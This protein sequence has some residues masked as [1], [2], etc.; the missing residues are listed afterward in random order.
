MRKTRKLSKRIAMRRAGA[1]AMA[2]VLTATSFNFPTNVYA[3]EYTSSWKKDVM[4][5]LDDVLDAMGNQSDYS[6]ALDNLNESLNNLESAATVEGL[7]VTEVGSDYIK[8]EWEPFASDELTGYDV[9]FADKDTETQV[10]Q[11]LTSDG[12]KTEDESV[13]TVGS[14]TTSFI[15]KKSTHKNYYF[16]V[17][18]VVA[19]NVGSKTESVK[20]PTANEFNA[21]LE[22][23]DRGLVMVETN[24]G[25]FLSWRLLG[26]EVTG[27]NSTGLTGTD[28]NVY[29]DGEYVATVT[30]STN[31]VVAGGTKD[32][33]YTVVPVVNG[34]EDKTSVS[35][36][37][38]LMNTTEGAG[39]LDIALQ[40]PHD[41][42][43]E[44]TYGV[45][46]AEITLLNSTRTDAYTTTNITYSANDV[47][48][49]DVDGDGEY[50][51]FV[52]WDPSLSKDV[53]QQGYT[54]KQYI[55]CYELDGTLLYR[56]DLG[57]NIRAGAHY[58]QFSVF[59][60]NEDGKAELSIKTA[61]GT[62][63]LTFNNNN[64]DDIATE[65]Y[66]TTP[67][68]ESNDA[69]Y[70]YSAADY[71]EH[72]VNMF[73]DWGVWANDSDSMRE[74]KEKWDKNLI[75]L[76]APEDGT[77]TR[78]INDN[79]TYTSEIV[80]REEAGF[81]EDDVLVNV[82]VRD[83]NGDVVYKGTGVANAYMETVRFDDAKTELTASMYHEGGYSREE[84]EALADYF[85]N[86]YQ[87]RMKKHNLNYYEGYIISG[88][89][90]LS[91]FEGATGR[92][93]D[94]IMYEF[95]REDDGMLWGDYAMNYME[96]G[97]RCDR[98]LTTVAYLDGENPY[99][100]V[101]RGYY[102]RATIATYRITKE[103]KLE[104]YWT[105]DSGWTVMTN[106]FN[107]GPHGM[108]GNN[109]N[110]GTNGISFSLFSGQ[111]D[112]YVV[113][114]DVD[115]DGRQEIVYGGAIVDDNGDLYSSG[116][117]L[118]PDGTWAKYG[119]GDSIHVTD[120]D[121]DRPGLEIFSCF[122]GGPGAP[123]GTA[124]RDAE[125]NTTIPG[126]FSV[127]TGLD[128]G[129]C[130]IGDI[131]PG[132]RGL[133]TWG[134]NT[135]D[136]KGNL[137]SASTIGTNQNIRWSADMTTQIYTGNIEKCEGNTKSVVL[138]ATGTAS[139]NGTKGN[140]G[141]IAD[142]FGDWREE[143]I[144]RTSDN[145]AL[146]IYTNTEVTSHK[147]YTLMHDTQYR[148]NVA[149]QNTAYNQPSY[150]GFYFA[151]DTDWEYVPLP[152]A[153][154]EQ[155]PGIVEVQPTGVTFAIS[156]LLVKTGDTKNVNATVVPAKATDKTLTYISS[157]NNIA[158]VDGNGDVT[159]VSAGTAIITA[160]T[161]NG[162]SM[163]CKVIVKDKYTDNGTDRFAIGDEKTYTFGSNG[164]VSAFTI[165][166]EETGYGFKTPNEVVLKDGED[167][168]SGN[169]V[170]KDNNGT[171]TYEYP[172]FVLDVPAG[173]YE[174]TLTQGSDDEDSVTGAYVEGN[175]YSVRWSSENFATSYDEPSENSYIITK[176]G[177]RKVTTVKTAVCDGQLTIDLAT[178]VK[179][180]GSSLTAYINN[181][182]VKRI[183]QDT[184]ESAN[185][186]LRFI[187][188]STVASY[189]PEDGGNWTPIP[190]RTGWGTDFAM[191]R[192]MD[193]SVTLV[194]KAV[195]GS[196]IKSYIA[197]GYYNDFF[198][199]SKPGDTVIIE[200]GINDSAAGRRYS[201]GTSYEEYLRYYIES[202][203][204]FG[205]DVILSSGTSS[206]TTYTAVQEKLA[207]EYELPY[208]DLL[209]EF[210]NYK[211][212]INQTAQG[213]LTVDGTHLSRVGGVLAAQIVANSIADIEGYSLSGHVL[214]KIVNDKA[215]QAVVTG[216]YKK[217]QTE[218][219]V[220]IAWNIDEDTLYN[221]DELI[222]RFNIY[223]KAKGEDDSK[224]E[225]V[226]Q[227]RAYVQASMTAPKLMATIES[228]EKGDYEYAVSVVG[229]KG[230][231]EK[232][233]SVCI[234]EFEKTD[235]YELNELI[236]KYDSKQMYDASHYTVE[237]Y[238][239]LIN[240]INKAKDSISREDVS[241][242][243]IKK[244]LEEV[245]SL[246]SA[247]KLNETELI[248]TDFE[249]EKTGSLWGTT[250]NQLL[251]VIMEEDGN[252]MANAYVEA[253]GTRNIKKTITGVDSKLLTVEFEWLP[254]NPDT[255]NCTEIQFSDASGVYFSLKTSNN[256]HIGYVV[257]AYPSDDTS[258]LTGDGFHEGNKYATDCNIPN[259]IWYNVRVVFDYEEHTADLYFVPR[260]NEEVAPVIV[261]DIAISEAASQVTLMNFLC[262]RGKQDNGVTND[263]SVLWNTYLDNFLISYSDTKEIVDASEYNEIVK[264]LD[265]A[266]EGIN[267]S[268][269]TDEIRLAYIIEDAI[270]KDTGYYTESDYEYAIKTIKQAINT[271]PTITKVTSINATDCTVLAGVKTTLNVTF[272]PENSNEVISAGSSSDALKVT[273]NGNKITVYSEEEITAT[274]TVKTAS[275]LTKDVK[276]NV[277]GKYYSFGTDAQ[278]N[279][280]SLYDSE[281]GYGFVNYEYPSEALG[282]VDG[283]YHKRVLR[284][285]LGTSYIDTEASTS[286]YLAVNSV[287]WREQ[288]GSR[289]EDYIR[290]E[291]TQAFVIDK[292]SGNYKVA[293]TFTNP[294]KT[295][296]TVSVIAQDIT[297]YSSGDHAGSELG[298][299]KLNAGET[300]TAEFE[301][302]LMDSQIVLRFE[303]DVT[304]DSYE[305]AYPQTVYVKGVTVA[306][307]E[308]EEKELNTIYVLGDSTV[309]TYTQTGYRTGWGQ[310]LYNILKGA[311]DNSIIEET[312]TG[313]ADYVTD[314]FEVKNYARDARSA[315]SFKE[316][317]RLNE[318]LL[319]VSEGDYVLAQ[320]THNDSNTA[321]PNRYLSE[322]EFRQY[323]LDY[324]E[325]VTKRGATFVMVTPIALNVCTDGNWDH[326][327]ESYRKVMLEL[328]KTDN[329]PVID[330][331][332]SS[333]ALL[334]ELGSDTVAALS[335]YMTDTV[336]LQKN[337]ADMYARLIANQINTY[338]QSNKLDS[339][340]NALKDSTDTVTLMAKE[341]ELNVN[342]TITLGVTYTGTQPDY[343]F[344]SSDEAVATVDEKGNVTA[345]GKGSAVI[346]AVV[347][348]GDTTSIDATVYTDYIIINVASEKEDEI[349]P[350][351]N[352]KV[353]SMES[354][355]SDIMTTKVAD[356]QAMINTYSNDSVKDEYI[357]DEVVALDVEDTNSENVSVDLNAEVEDKM[358]KAM[359]KFDFG[360]K[361]GAATGYTN[362]TNQAYTK[363]IGYGFTS[364]TS[365]INY[366]S[367]SVGATLKDGADEEEQALTAACQDA[368]R[369]SEFEFAIDL[370]A[371]TY[372]LTMYKNADW[373]L[374]MYQNATYTVNGVP[375]RGITTVTSTPSEIAD[376][377]KVTLKEDGQ[378]IVKG[379]N[380]NKLAIMN[381]IV[382]SEYVD[383][384]KDYDADAFATLEED[385]TKL[386]I[387]ASL[388]ADDSTP[389]DYDAGLVNRM[390]T[391]KDDLRT[392]KNMKFIDLKST[393]EAKELAREALANKNLYT[394]KSIENLNKALEVLALVEDNANGT[395][396]IVKSAINTINYWLAGI[397]TDNV[398]ETYN[399]YVDFDYVSTSVEYL[400][401]GYTSVLNTD[402]YDAEKGYGLS[403]A[404][405]GRNRGTGDSLNDDFV[406]NNTF[407]A[408][409][410]AGTYI[411]R[412]ICGDLLSGANNTSKFTITDAT[413]GNILLS[414]VSVA[415]AGGSVNSVDMTLTLNADTQVNITFT[416]RLNALLIDEKKAI[417][418]QDVDITELKELVEEIT[419]KELQEDDYTVSSFNALTEALKDA[420]EL[421]AKETVYAQEY[422]KVLSALKSA[423]EGLVPKNLDREI[424][425]DF[426]TETSPVSTASKFSGDGGIDILGSEVI[427]GL[428]SML[429]SSNVTDNGQHFG[430]DREVL[431]NETSAGGAHFRDYV[432]TA[433]GEEY[434]FS[435]DLP[436]GTYYIY[437][438]TGDKLADN[439]TK[440]YLGDN[441]EVVNSNNAAV[442]EKDGKTVYTQ[443]SN[444]GGQ[445]AAPGAIYTVK[446][447][448]SEVAC[449]YTG[450]K[451]GRFSVTL[452]NDE[453][454]ADAITARLN[455]IEIT[456]FDKNEPL[457][458]DEKVPEH[459]HN[460][461]LTEEKEATCTEDGYKTYTCECGDSY[462][463]T[464]S[465]TGHNYELTEEK[466]ATC[467]EDG[468]R[469]YTCA[470][471]KDTYK[472]VI[473]ATGH[474]EGEWVV[475]KEAGKTEDGVRS[476]I[477]TKCN[478]VLDTEV[479]PNLFSQVTVADT[480]DVIIRSR[481][482]PQITLPAGLTMSDIKVSYTS[483]RPYV[484]LPSNSN[485]D[486]V[487]VL[488]G[489]ATITTTI[490]CED[491]TRTFTTFVTIDFP[492][493]EIVNGDLTLARGEQVKLQVKGVGLTG[494]FRY[495]STNPFVVKVTSDGEI[496]ALRKGTSYVY[497]YNN[498]ALDKIKV[499]VR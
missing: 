189:P 52:K 190:E 72:L 323:L 348:N 47:S 93:L 26:S 465:A 236:E 406:M 346:T 276:V 128:T 163:T 263:L 445:F 499:V 16:K 281:K 492:E 458:P 31:Y 108:N 225:K 327:F 435:M 149:G 57:I 214:K 50:E 315:K 55:D 231:G 356:S 490:T 45:S 167:Y 331:M 140:A 46:T 22:N 349:N 227:Q 338:N 216:V 9:Y 114:A 475:T 414:D 64:Q 358:P 383:E 62:K 126:K 161:V 249:D 142:I 70:V 416:G 378:V 232:S 330:L 294:S 178:A 466:E 206:G 222:T 48:V 103:G 59:D 106:P 14:D 27:Y 157:D 25:V 434:T 73:M 123:F 347:S 212:T 317:G 66:I 135:T 6:N 112:H 491:V 21:Y 36:D 13:V 101:C 67:D 310:V 269:Y 110:V 390:L 362:I 174:V 169:N 76:F 286:D 440:F 389:L 485:G 436:V 109:T 288:A 173:I 478:E 399:L 257:G 91:V 463:E 267:E 78:V 391:V 277:N 402:L 184:E 298:Q 49:G 410:K 32:S 337:G 477:C 155:E 274:V 266:V 411:L 329:I 287:I 186:T 460:Y 63:V 197:D 201:D 497:V 373:N 355:V 85:L 223:R 122:E 488:A 375:V 56:I 97:N 361:A 382:V 283:V 377:V 343:R 325:A 42:T 100:V 129:R 137:V 319:G 185:P 400:T 94:T 423:Y 250:G 10:F 474:D 264:E 2:A 296:E 447:S 386:Q 359:L 12:Q 428:P 275:G 278:I 251:S 442:S 291:N 398:S 300:K 496:V 11:K 454:A 152:N 408:D 393:D 182:T 370:K 260:D 159:G 455:G 438:Y 318:V 145:S 424:L 322:E 243:E 181:I 305:S 117:D 61:P 498:G 87:Y 461:V 456:P 268:A 426:G 364:D 96:P 183:A 203:K 259:N 44:E 412:A 158:T 113:A 124:L 254:G 425:I 58:T 457:V 308:A 484:A 262:M 422:N 151:S 148:A 17:A 81:T 23:L 7:T 141:L 476:L 230:E 350:L 219:S 480:A 379:N 357:S 211:A 171:V 335:M 405:N 285:T 401:K 280:N 221:P 147:M 301:L 120:I 437:M 272:E 187:G 38:K 471:C 146:R 381:A 297:R 427:Q 449:G 334:N 396:D 33:K 166:S 332:G 256:G 479:I 150:V 430:F 464:V 420:K 105:I 387:K 353:L 92:E 86:G 15:Y 102:T 156:S 292:E 328:A 53:S 207:A 41:T 20:S 19:G 369:A 397:D 468:Y 194:N 470:S 125:T 311:S 119:H 5:S 224:Y 205:L 304:A 172:E 270:S 134:V 202:C 258:Y 193:E 307:K 495:V 352:L 244:V 336:H 446:V 326:R 279:N 24:E 407:I 88:S 51:F 107:D 451:M 252:R 265:K 138:N 403:T 234:K 40:Q 344:Y 54:G 111:G 196:S 365:L 237:S 253:A 177:D 339:L 316:E 433:G 116:G 459:E 366:A 248:K 380:G 394:E 313:Y 1:L 467:T 168:V 131:L 493:L 84:A 469:L 312:S 392:V 98:F 368:V 43:I 104:L 462:T 34:T 303:K 179:A 195:A 83:E 342:D 198:L 217:A 363:E 340:K 452:F 28:F 65:T 188:D 74:A 241:D 261:R 180:E 218:S 404:A 345:K 483:D 376:S 489:F 487:A 240:A 37:A 302:A 282:V 306:Q 200:G 314:N 132:V 395:K 431:A 320:F 165:Y 213:D 371:G 35:E 242:E 75:N 4:S 443:T 293:V 453:T 419:A 175:M 245:K 384:V 341:A 409:L 204:A 494:T 80:S 60:F 127:Y 324:N 143:L 82:P 233:S 209:T 299:V 69:D 374:G 71:R 139:N 421:L 273:V 3:D 444:G 429:Y 130:M 228:P 39:Y 309:Q 360:M 121:P 144:T 210:N 192:F 229:L 99:L 351:S 255:R 413:T 176:K 164:T 68:G 133:E 153:K 472:D 95:E 473:N 295:D 432:Y 199:T 118:L 136:A 77:V 90:Y 220:T 385:I 247:L 191:G 154:K 208:V 115:E 79:G 289:D 89:E 441:C 448:E 170:R 8:I 354:Y 18:P 372:M 290:Y 367:L 333:Y 235:R 482:A 481:F 271:V 29:K 417:S 388:M 486:I 321:R 450:Y 284:T 418:A 239:A 215:P 246:E 439:T 160:T 162:I 238:V 30:D 226:G 415:S